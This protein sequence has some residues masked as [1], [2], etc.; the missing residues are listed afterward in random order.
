[1][2][3]SWNLGCNESIPEHSDLM[4]GDPTQYFLSSIWEGLHGPPALV[5]RVAFVGSGALPSVFAVADF[6]ASAIGAAGLAVGELLSASGDHAAQVTV[7]RK[8]A[9]LWYG[10]SIQPMGWSLPAPWDPIAGDYEA[11]DGWIRLHTNAP[12]HRAAALA[13][14][15]VTPERET[16]A[17]SVSK[18]KAA[19]LQDAVVSAGGCAAAMYSLQEWRGHPQGSAAMAEPLVHIH[20]GADQSASKWRPDSSQPLRGLRVL[21]LTRV[22]AGPVATRFLAAF[23]A[24]V[25]RIDPPA[26]DEPAVV[27]DV[28]V[29][30]RCARLDLRT[31]MERAVLERLLQG[32][33]VLIHG[34]RADALAA[35]GF[36]A[37]RRRE[38]RPG[39]I[40][41]SLN[42]YGWSGPWCN[43]R[44][45]DSLVQMSSGIADEGMRRLARPR[46]TPLPVQ[47][48]DHATG[49]LMAAAAIRGLTERLTTSYSYQARLS[50]ARTAGVLIDGPPGDAGAIAVSAD[51]SDWSAELE[52]T[53]WGPARR[54]R[55]PVTIG[56]V[57][58]QWDRP[59]AH[60]GSSP[61]AW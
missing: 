48:L 28:T 30:K 32:A 51:E 4:P 59:A 13:V 41:V 43:R 36:D 61:A 18:W 53:D 11:A 45:F 16:V 35:M 37:D 34:Y 60:L 9:S 57:A 40:D 7:D 24:H 22:L 54:L 8:L 15:G 23:G 26:W 39:L 38:L 33:D 49:Y 21:D 50:L 55:G 12:H 47:A 14:L 1:M 46:P 3:F 17:R 20:R 42:A 19:A 6:A 31:P 29:G 58:M 44:G 52:Q 25:L 5:S 10:W 2:L 27:P 56:D